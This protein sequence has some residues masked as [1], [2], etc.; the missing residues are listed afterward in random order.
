MI[1]KL[2]IIILI[3]L[4]IICAAIIYLSNVNN[5]Q[6]VDLY[7]YDNTSYN[8]LCKEIQD[9]GIVKN[10]TLF[11]L[12]AKALDYKDN[13]KSGHYSIEP[14][15]R[16]INFVYNLIK[17]RQQ[18]IKLIVGKSRLVE[19]FVQK[20]SEN[21]MFSS[22]N[23]LSELKNE[24]IDDSIFFFTIPNTY[25]CYW[26]ISPKDFILRMRKES[27]KFWKNKKNDIERIGLSQYQVIILASIIEEETN[28]NEEKP[29]IAGVYINRLNK[30]MLL[31]ADPTIKYAIKNFEL[32]RIKGDMLNTLSPYN[33]Y[34]FK[35][36]PPFPICLPSI[37]SINAVLNYEK[38]DF[39]FF[40]AKEDFSGY[41][42]FAVTV[43]EHLENSRKYHKILGEK[44]IK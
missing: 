12:Y 5:N 19:D 20:I 31:Q 2:I 27:D 41:H 35:G 24:N 7:L 34:K 29:T 28:K 25:E 8:D 44:G 42:N 11:N 22:D 39:L 21:F 23:L 36:L 4:C 26:T 18:P 6:K 15:T 40:C 16:L 3:T 10:L 30:N 37:S 33:T 32:K 38:H 13:I 17:G 14:K 43:A 1:K 9:K